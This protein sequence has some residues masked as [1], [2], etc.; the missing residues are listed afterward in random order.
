MKAL[1]LA[2][3]LSITASVAACNGHLDVGSTSPSGQDISNR[4]ASS[5]SGAS[6]SIG[7]AASSSGAPE[8]V[9]AGSVGP[10]PGP[11]SYTI[12]GTINGTAF[13]PA[14]AI[15]FRGDWVGGTDYPEGQ[16][17]R[18]FFS[19]H[20]ELNCDE[21]PAIRN[22][23]WFRLEIKEADAHDV[24]SLSATNHVFLD[25]ADASC[26]TSPT[27]PTSGTVTLKSV[28]NGRVLGGVDGVT[29]AN[30]TISGNFSIPICSHEPMSEPLCQ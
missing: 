26:E 4:Q 28:E 12:N 21:Y 13:K 17:L 5:S 19:D 10:D 3:L 24:A 20:D 30:G 16:Y 2:S 6:G 23:V 22:S 7:A 14:S 8:V 29:F 15:A 11:A 18:V 25:V 27:A 1:L 9:D